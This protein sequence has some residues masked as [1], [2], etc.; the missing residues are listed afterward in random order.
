M[1]GIGDKHSVNASF[2]LV[3]RKS[4]SSICGDT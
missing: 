2:I 4:L 1:G 3:R